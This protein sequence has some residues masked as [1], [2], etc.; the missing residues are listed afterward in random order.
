MAKSKNHTNHNQGLYF[1]CIA[2]VLHVKDMIL[3]FFPVSMYCVEYLGHK[4]HRNGIKKPKKQRYPSLKGV[5]FQQC[6]SVLLALVSYFLLHV[7]YL[8]I[9]PTIVAIT[10]LI[11]EGLF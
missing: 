11:M 10:W 5:S 9:S 8:R 6:V 2:V 7:H 1:S 3:F 4:W